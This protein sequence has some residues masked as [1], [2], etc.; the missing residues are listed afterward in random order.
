MCV[1]LTIC[2]QDSKPSTRPAV[3]CDEKVV[4]ACAIIADELIAARALIESQDKEI[5]AAT[6]RLDVE[7]EQIILHREK[8]ELLA[9]R[10]EALQSQIQSLQEASAIMA[11]LNDRNRERIA[12]L[13]AQKKAANKRTLIAAVAGIGFGILIRR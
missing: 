5:K 11:E 9:R 8:A 7:K 10:I 1:Q 12:K 2:A 3:E 6:Q 4:K 13:E